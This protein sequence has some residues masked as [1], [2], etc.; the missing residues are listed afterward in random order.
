M[1]IFG[2]GLGRT[3]TR[4]LS[5][6]MH[7]LGYKSKHAPK[8]FDIILD[9]DFL[10][11]IEISWRFEFFDDFFPNSKFIFT[12]RDINTWM[13]SCRNRKGLSNNL[14]IAQNRYMMYNIRGFDEKKFR[15][16]YYEYHAR[17]YK[18]FENREKDLLIMNIV[19]GDGWKKLCK[20]LDKEIPDMDFP[21]RHK[22]NF[23]VKD[24]R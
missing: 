10:N 20:F 14:R 21:H 24:K 4:S 12:T 19:A 8:D 17:V 23:E 9:Y 5:K 3:G 13:E 6:S 2:I 11:D 22:T 7:I 15:I 16:S 18:Y 1:K